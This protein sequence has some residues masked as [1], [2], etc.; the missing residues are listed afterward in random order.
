MMTEKEFDDA[1]IRAKQAVNFWFGQDMTVTITGLYENGFTYS[2][3]TPYVIFNGMF[4][5]G[6][7]YDNGSDSSCTEIV[8]NR[9]K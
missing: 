8:I 1:I 9:R 6:S 2:R 5:Y 7:D 4:A 3:V